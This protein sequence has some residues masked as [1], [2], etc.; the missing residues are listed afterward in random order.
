MVV[1]SSPEDVYW[2][3]F[4]ADQAQDA[5]AWASLLSYPHIR[6]AATGRIE[7]F[8]TLEE[9]AAQTEWKKR[10]ASGWIRTEGIDPIRI[11]TTPSCVHLAGGW[12]RYNA[13]N[14]PLLQNRV[15]YV[16]QRRAG[17]WGI[18]ARLACGSSPIWHDSLD[19][20][21]K[22]SVIRFF[23][24]V[25]SGEMMKSCVK[26]IRMPF[27]YIDQTDLVQIERAIEFNAI[28]EDWCSR[29]ITKIDARTIQNGPQG[30]NVA[31]SMQLGSDMTIFA[32]ALVEKSPSACRIATI[33]CCP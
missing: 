6:V 32:L 22:I 19:D 3:Y 18:R 10:L 2:A 7:K 24:L 11:H 26:L 4:R 12:T 14:Q 28:F 5:Y 27:V 17:T 1:E 25:T 21:P 15:V 20:K 16:M 31:V 29:D 30:A 9:C 8:G 13:N 23:N 33:S